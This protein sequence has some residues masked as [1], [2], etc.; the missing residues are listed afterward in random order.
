MKS[1]RWRYAWAWTIGATLLT[2]AAC[3]GNPA[4]QPP[5]VP[6][7]EPTPICNP[8]ETCGCW[9]QPPGQDWQRLP[10]CGAPPAPGGC[11]IDGL[12]GPKLET[13]DATLG[14][15]VN[16]AILAV[17][18]CS[19]GRCV[20]QDGRQ[21][22]QA[23][24]VAE[25]RR[26]GVCAGQHEPGVTDEIAVSTSTTATRESYHVYAGPPEGPGT[27]V[28][29]PQ[30]V[31]PSYAAP[32]SSPPPPPPPPP[33]VPPTSGCGAPVPPPLHS[34]VVHVRDVRD[35]WQWIDSTPLVEGAAYCAAI[36]Y[37]RNPCPI[38][39]EGAADRLA[40]EQLVLGAPAPT[41]VW[42]GQPSDGWI[43]E[44]SRGF[45]FDRRKG[46]DGALKVCNAALTTCTEVPR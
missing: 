40:C 2:L 19:G 42:T 32:G 8:G 20:V 1:N 35:G 12:P 15:Q 6:A 18:G 29:S 24:I 33:P 16:A 21:V 11:S 3:A 31:R 26:A 7:P 44:G 36:G 43:R 34:F 37:A 22:A 38:R 27:L 9:H 45:G 25:L 13:A 30:A 28:L 14:G 17:Y 10:D 39:T 5:P 46:A 4:P 41:W 23:K